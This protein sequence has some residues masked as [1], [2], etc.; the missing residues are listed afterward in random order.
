MSDT[1]NVSNVL[2]ALWVPTADGGSARITTG[3]AATAG[4]ILYS[5]GPTIATWTD[6]RGEIE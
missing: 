1:S 5:T 4:Q 6:L 3:G 2:S